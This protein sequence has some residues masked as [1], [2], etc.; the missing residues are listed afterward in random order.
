MAGPIRMGGLVSG[1][2]TDTIIKNLM[3][4][5]KA[6]L[7]KMLQLK[8][9]E[10]WKRDQY[11]EMNN[12][13]LDFRKAS[14]GL[15]L[16]ANFQKKAISSDND[17]VV[18]VTQK[19]TPTLSSYDV[20]VTGLATPAKAASVKFTTS[21]DSTTPIGET[22]S[23][24]VGSKSIDV[25]A[26]D[27]MSN[28]ISKINAQ[29][30]TTGVTASY[31]QG[32]KSITFTSK[33]TGSAAS[34]TI[35]GAFGASNKLGL[36]AGTVDKNSTAFAGATAFQASKDALPGNVKIN[37]ID[38]AFTG[39]SLTFDGLEFNLKSVG[40]TRVNMKTDEDAIFNSIKGFADKYNE[41]ISKVNTKLTESKYNDYKPL[42]DEE[43]EAMNET[44][45]EKWEAK[46]QSGLLR[47]DSILSGALTDF[48]K[49]LTDRVEGSGIDPKFDT[50]SEIGI[51][52]GG[53]Q[54]N[55][56]LYIDEDKLRQA[57]SQNG[58]QVMDLFTK[59]SADTDR[60]KNFKES[61]IA[62]RL[63]AQVNNSIKDLTDKAG[64]SAYL[65]DKSVLGKELRELDTNIRSWKER[66][67]KKE[68]SY[69]RKFTAMEKAM[70]QANSQSSWLSQQTG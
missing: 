26:T 52:T 31:V 35:G 9:S 19:G 13:L 50:L 68:D 67:E 51:T 55:G 42:L 22:F 20:N 17:G 45:I 3:K 57:I 11:R 33:A 62:Q 46:A 56:K 32:D 2:D 64:S 38:Y 70:S 24:T 27:T 49:V 48:R 8:Q 7:N 23:F 21:L 54:E 59:Y 4:A 36:S 1:L 16:Q 18:S 39:S 69:W 44:Q 47:R 30:S 53:Y 15:R 28:V 40:S 65:S 5:E 6:P 37:G 29:S 41:L 66:L 12:L 10:E 43:K 14:E 61:G 60:T 63:Y 34:V 25:A 58:T